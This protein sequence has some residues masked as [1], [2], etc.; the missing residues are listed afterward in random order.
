MS[1]NKVWEIYYARRVRVA[2]MCPYCKAYF[3]IE[4]LAGVEGPSGEGYGLVEN[5]I[6]CP[7]CGD[8]FHVK[9]CIKY[10]HDERVKDV[11]IYSHGWDGGCI[12]W[13][14]RGP[15]DWRVLDLTEGKPS[16]GWSSSSSSDPKVGAVS[17]VRKVGPI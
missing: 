6:K 16:Y 8:T 2:I 3:V 15:I 13:P 17:N 7:S 1:E 5:P 10:D 4:G 12:G 14:I 9:L 11:Y